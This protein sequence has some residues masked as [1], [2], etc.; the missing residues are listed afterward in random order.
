MQQIEGNLLTKYETELPKVNYLSFFLNDMQQLESKLLTKYKTE[1]SKA[2]Y[3][4]FFF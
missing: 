3:L 2:I 4:S 1:S